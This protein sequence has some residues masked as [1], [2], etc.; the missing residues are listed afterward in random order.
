MKSLDR[1]S[2]TSRFN[3]VANKGKVKQV[4][5]PKGKNSA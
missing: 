1:F 2:Q 4:I 3:Q 5:D